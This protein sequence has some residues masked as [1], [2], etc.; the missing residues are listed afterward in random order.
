MPELPV[1]ERPVAH[2]ERPDGSRLTLVGVDAD[3]YVF[4]TVRRHRRFYEADLLD[5]ITGL[6]LPPGSLCV[7]VGANIGNHTLHLAAVLGHPVLAIEPEAT[8][9]AALRATIAANELEDRV[10]VLEVALGAATGTVALAQRVDGNRGTFRTVTGDAVACRRLDDVVPED[11]TVGLVKIDVEG[12][13]TAVLA[14][15]VELLERDR[16]FLSLEAHDP[17]S[18][19]ELD[20]LLRPL[21]YRLLGTYGRSDNLLFGADDGEVS[22]ATAAA[23]RLRQRTGRTRHRELLSGLEHVRMRTDA[24]DRVTRAELAQLR[25]EV[26]RRG[27][28]LRRARAD[29][30]RAE[31]RVRD[32]RHHARREAAANRQLR[33]EVELWQE[34]YGHLAA[35]RALRTADRVRA[36]A[37]RTGLVER[38][39][40]PSVE[41]RAK[42]IRRL[43]VAEATSPTSRPP[44]AR[45]RNLR[46]LARPPVRVAIAS[47]AS[48]VDGLERVVAALLPQVDDLCVHLNDHDE[49]PG[50]LRDPRITVALGPD[51]GDRGKFEFLAGFAGYYLTCDDDIDYPPYYVA[52]LLDGIERYG[53]RAV[54]GWHGSRILEPFSDYY[55]PASRHVIAFWK[56]RKHD[57]AVHVLGTGCA[58]FHTDTI[59][60][61]PDDL[62]TPNMADVHVALLGQR[63]RV[64]FVVLA[65][66]DRDATPIELAEPTSISG[67]SMAAADHRLNVRALTNELVGGHTWRLNKARLIHARPRLRVAFIGRVDEARWRKGGILRSAHLTAQMLRT[68]GVEVELIDLVSDEAQRQRDVEADVVMIY[69]GDPERP[70]FAP[71]EDLVSHHAAAGRLVLVNLSYNARPS[72][73]AFILD[74]MTRW[75]ATTPGRVRLLVFS[76]DLVDH[77]DLAKIRELVVALPKTLDLPAGRTADVARSRGVFLGDYGK[78]C[79]DR[80]LDTPVERWVDAIRAALPDVPLFAL[81]Q[82]RPAEAKALGLEIRPYVPGPLA[83]DLANVRLMVSPFRYC[84]FEMVPIE[85]AAA[86]LPVVYRRME[87]SLSSYL[88][89]AG[90]PV[91]GPDDLATVLPMLY[92]DPSVWTGLSRAGELR[93]RSGDRDVQAAALYLRLRALVERDRA[94]RE[95]RPTG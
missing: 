81:A 46:S 67:T 9:A 91:A 52:H 37:A 92:H 85:L 68:F 35:S 8:N 40:A 31:S 45:G 95:S 88:G 10:D 51:L 94:N 49:V 90:V 87:Q 17:A 62:P 7:D 22:P 43:A 58:G 44:R 57:Q 65:H 61:H 5:A 75:E 80:L 12:D 48:R 72:R 13:E 32:E 53:R 11:A 25:E 3:E 4:A 34:A 93:A 27:D 28:E 76:D 6:P 69:P 84:T 39:S 66:A 15:A 1:D 50:F 30:D 2:V 82:Y 41:Q 73:T 18:A 47:I 38:H 86:G 42:R 56:G 26:A 20:D 64:P 83:E 79:D 23:E 33:R 19:R 24:D 78:L 74:R 29:L 54:V 89:A 16:P 59:R 55:D 36:V 21:G 70:D 77:P 14:G 71:V 60:I 63:Q